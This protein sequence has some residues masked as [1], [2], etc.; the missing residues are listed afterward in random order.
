ME[1]AALNWCLHNPASTR[2]S[3]GQYRYGNIERSRNRCNTRNDRTG[4]SGLCDFAVGEQDSIANVVTVVLLPHANKN[5]QQAIHPLRIAP[6]TQQYKNLF[7]FS[8]EGQGLLAVFPIEVWTE[9]R[10]IHIVFDTGIPSS[11]GPNA[12]GGCTSSKVRID[13][14]RVR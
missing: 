9:D 7:G 8:A 14:G 12:L 2:C 1:L 10:D 13:L 11:N 4:N 3:S 6:A 5:S